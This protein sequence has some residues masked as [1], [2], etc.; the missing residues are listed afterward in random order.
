[1]EKVRKSSF[2]KITC[3]IIIPIIVAILGLS[4]FHIAFLNEFGKEEEEK[5]YFQTEMFA[6]NYFYYFIEKIAQHQ[7][8]E[9]IQL[10]DEKGKIYY[11]SNER[12]FYSNHNSIGRYI[13]YI[14][15]DRQTR[16]HVYKYEKQ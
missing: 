6:N 1:M 13:Y 4:I 7:N 10:Q 14:M 16:N 8:H 9:D 15:I 11:Y 3:Y 5:Q 2:L 12:N